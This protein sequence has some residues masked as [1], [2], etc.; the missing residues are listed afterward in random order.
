LSPATILIVALQAQRQRIG[1]TRA[2]AVEPVF[3]VADECRRRC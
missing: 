1:I 2:L 3:V